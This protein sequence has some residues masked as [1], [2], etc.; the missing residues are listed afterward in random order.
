MIVSLIINKFLYSI[1]GGIFSGAAG[2]GALS[3]G[4][5]GCCRVLGD[6]FV[7]ANLRALAALDADIGL[8]AVTLGNDPDTAVILVELLVEGGG[9]GADAF[10]AGHARNVLLDGE[11][12][13]GRNLLLLYA[14]R[15]T[16]SPGPEENPLSLEKRRLPAHS[17]FN[18]GPLYMVYPQ[19]A[20][21]F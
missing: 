5:V 21:L 3:A 6:G 18:A 19:I 15:Q 8:C 7:L 9:A 12:L 11:L 2:I 1:A 10:Q 17:I 20:I 16:K 13:H 14:G 4:V